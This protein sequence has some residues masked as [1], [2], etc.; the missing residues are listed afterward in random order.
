[1]TRCR[2]FAVCLLLFFASVAFGQNSGVVKPAALAISEKPL[3]PQLVKHLDNLPRRIRDRAGNLGDMVNF[4]IVGSQE[5][6]QSALAEADWQIADRTMKAA[7]SNAFVTTTRKK[8]YTQMPMSTLYL[9]DRPQDFGYEQAEAY[10]VVAERHHFRIW[11]AFQWNGQT[12]WAGAGTHDVG[13]ERD[14]RRAKT[15]THKID[16]AVDGERNHI[17]RT[18]QTAGKVK[19]MHYYLPPRPI[20]EARNATGGSYHSDGRLLIIFL[21]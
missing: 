11:K 3:D 14:R 12:V 21:R 15:V 2:S 16:P 6:T 1:M 19:T 20:K 13:I 9:F 7:V 4:V 17:G 18:L 5:Q 8:G 10:K